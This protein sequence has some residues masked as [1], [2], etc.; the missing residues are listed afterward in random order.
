ME[1]WINYSASF[2]C[3]TV[4]LRY[5]VWG[6]YSINMW[7]VVPDKT[8]EC[9]EHCSVYDEGGRGRAVGKVFFQLERTCSRFC[10]RWASQLLLG[11]SGVIWKRPSE[12]SVCC[13]WSHSAVKCVSD[14]PWMPNVVSKRILLFSSSAG[15][16]FA[17]LG[18]Y[19]IML[20]ASCSVVSVLTLRT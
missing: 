11:E 9:V 13:V 5:V 7:T 12:D 6:T 16:Q 18:V 4:I 3:S 20:M 10:L 8:M 2:S 14:W 17:F 1:H 19:G 15:R